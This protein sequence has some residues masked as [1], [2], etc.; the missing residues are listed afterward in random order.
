M[1]EGFVACPWN[2]TGFQMPRYKGIKIGLFLDNWFSLRFNISVWD[3]GGG[4]SSSQAGLGHMPLH[5]RG[6]LSNFSSLMEARN[7]VWVADIAF[8]PALVSWGSEWNG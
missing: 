3:G 1:I 2:P 5:N 4:H 6:A 8:R 7:R